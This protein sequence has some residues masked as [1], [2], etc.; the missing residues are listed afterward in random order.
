M[1]QVLIL[2]EIHALYRLKFID[3]LI[4]FGKCSSVLFY[5]LKPA[6]AVRIVHIVLSPLGMT[7]G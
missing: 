2:C 1:L 4:T 6:D 5:L 3:M 7:L